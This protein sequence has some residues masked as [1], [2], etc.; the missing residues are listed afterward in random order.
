M[1]SVKCK[2]T[3]TDQMR[4]ILCNNGRYQTRDEGFLKAM[5]R[6]CLT[7]CFAHLATESQQYFRNHRVSLERLEAT[8]FLSFE[9][10]PVVMGDYGVGNM[11]CLV[12]LKARRGLA[13][14]PRPM[15]ILAQKAIEEE[16]QRRVEESRAAKRDEKAERKAR[17]VTADL[18][19][20]AQQQAHDD[21]KVAGST[22]AYAA[23][24][25]E[26][27][28]LRQ[29]IADLEAQ[30]QLQAHALDRSKRDS[31]S[32]RGASVPAVTLE[33]LLPGGELQHMSKHSTYMDPLCLEHYFR[34]LEV[35]SVFQR[36]MKHGPGGYTLEWQQRVLF[37]LLMFRRGADT[38]HTLHV[39]GFSPN[40]RW[41]VQRSFTA[42]VVCLCDWI[43]RTHG[44]S[45][46]RDMLEA[47]RADLFKGKFSDVDLVADA[48][49]TATP[50]HSSHFVQHL[51][52]SSYY[53][54]CC[55]KWVVGMAPNGLLTWCS[56]FGV[57]SSSDYKTCVGSKLAEALLDGSTLLYDKG[58][59][60]LREYLEERGKGYLCP[61]QKTAGA[62]TVHELRRSAEI[63]SRRCH[64]ERLVKKVKGFKI[65][66][67]PL[68]HAYFPIADVILYVCAFLTQ[69]T[70]PL[71]FN[72]PE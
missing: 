56:R 37:S 2:D 54:M 45:W 71:S 30:V 11:E 15:G 51:L 31:D 72:P 44:R 66:D 13:D 64:V 27:L 36:A 22:M 47:S 63:S 18:E 29:R 32:L 34:A 69:W 10:D 65:L 61:Y 6:K 24:S 46:T 67:T 55:G 62:L 39:M 5:G 9:D 59:G 8:D 14:V 20:L 16:A 48:S 26:L 12:A 52:Y 58:G 50:K 7:F 53:S 40:R 57:G 3:Q 68:S 25:E 60:S 38:T 23:Q 42:T 4:D 41:T 1:F 17:R 70:G 43:E 33:A 21:L 49:N 35:D 28:A 19:Q